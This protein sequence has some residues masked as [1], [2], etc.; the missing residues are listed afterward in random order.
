TYRD[1]RAAGTVHLLIGT[2]GAAATGWLMQRRLGRGPATAVAAAVSIGGRMLGDEASAV[3]RLLTDH[4]LDGAR[5]RIRS[6]VGRDTA[7]LDEGELSRAVIESLAENTVDAVT[8][9]LVWALVG[10]APA[11]LAHRAINTLDAMVGHRTQRYLRFGW[12]S[13]RADDV[14]NWLPAR[15]TAMA[16]AGSMP[17]RAGV[18]ARTVR[19][20]APQHP[21]PN[22]GVIEAAFAG[23]LD[24]RLGGTN[25]YAG[26]VEGRGV[27]G[28]GREAAMDDIG[29]AVALARRVAL[30]MAAVGVMIGCG[31]GAAR[32]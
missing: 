2:G 1:H 11:V 4:D 22:G 29:R 6:L 7:H 24:I 8:A 19:R 17:A 16:V 13:A 3:A 23:A 28:D 25:E 5:R 21:S 12:A 18:V 15:L 27:L 14:V 32:R 30:L 20:D 26:H 10:G 31:V 9:P